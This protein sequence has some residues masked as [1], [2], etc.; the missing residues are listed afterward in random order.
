MHTLLMGLAQLLSARKETPARIKAY[1]RAAKSIRSLSES[2]DDLVRE[3]ADLTRY[4]G[5][6]KGISGAIRELIVSGSLRQ[7]E[8]LRTQVSPEVAAIAAFPRLDPARVLRIYKKLGIG[9]IEELKERLEAGE[10][11]AKL[12]ERMESHVRQALAETHEM[13]L[14]AKTRTVFLR[15]KPYNA[16]PRCDSGTGPEVR[17]R[18]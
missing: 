8:T 12:G 11:A 5:I 6:G 14:Y 18:R 9:T 17:S 16:L 4:A 3:G 13:L 1:R 10:I 15:V 7:L 2:L